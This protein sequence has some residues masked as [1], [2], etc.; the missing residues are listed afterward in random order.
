MKLEWENEGKGAVQLLLVSCGR[1]RIA[2]LHLEMPQRSCIL[3][4]LECCLHKLMEGALTNTT[5][6]CVY[7]KQEKCIY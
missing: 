5:A 4:I 6:V 2:V 1:N 7:D 3:W